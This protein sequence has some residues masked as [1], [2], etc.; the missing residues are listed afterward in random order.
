MALAIVVATF[1]LM[2]GVAFA[3]LGA[4][5]LKKHRQRQ[6]PEPW[7]ETMADPGVG[8]TGGI[9]LLFMGACAAQLFFGTIALCG[10]LLAG[11][12]LGILVHYW[13]YGRT[14]QGEG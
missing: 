4:S 7:L 1:V 10:V 6:S 8:A 3:C 12:P 13:L 9:L 11:W 5:S 2:S 14:R